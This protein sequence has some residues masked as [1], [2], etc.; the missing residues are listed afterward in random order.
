MFLRR[1]TYRILKLYNL[2]E[3]MRIFCF[4]VRYKTDQALLWQMFN[5]DVYPVPRLQSP[6][7][8]VR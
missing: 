7:S 4:L 3:I 1:I 5:F 8:K 2:N 6:L